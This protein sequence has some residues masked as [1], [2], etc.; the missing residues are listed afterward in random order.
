MS[1][2]FRSFLLIFPI[3]EALAYFGCPQFVFGID[4]ALVL[5]YNVIM[6]C[7]R[8][9]GPI[10]SETNCCNYCGSWNGVPSRPEQPQPQPR[11][12]HAPPPPVRKKSGGGIPALV[13]AIIFG[14]PGVALIIFGVLSTRGNGL[15][16]LGGVLLVLGVIIAL[17]ILAIAAAVS[18]AAGVAVGVSQGISRGMENSLK[19][20]GAEVGAALTEVGAALKEV[21]GEF[22]NRFGPCSF[23][24][25]ITRE[26]F[27][28]IQTG[29]PVEHVEAMFGKG[30]ETYCASGLRVLIWQES[31][32]Q[33]QSQNRK[34]V[35]IKFVDGRVAEK[36]QFGL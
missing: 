18:A 29:T 22:F 10:N 26:K 35:T 2:R 31:I 12:Q 11:P 16:W 17:I 15:I 20:V 13:L 19:G 30:K 23:T 3:F 24:N 32:I 14:A 1:S 36:H 5:I 4:T 6:F 21:G 33:N 25:R 9:G 34:V 8:C 7:E 28:S 27:D